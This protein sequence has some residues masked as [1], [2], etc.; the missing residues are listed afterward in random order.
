MPDQHDGQ[1]FDGAVLRQRGRRQRDA[2]PFLDVEQ[3][4][5]RL[6]E[7]AAQ[8]EKV[9]AHDEQVHIPQAWRGDTP[10]VGQF[11]HGAYWNEFAEQIEAPPQIIDVTSAHRPVKDGAAMIENSGA[12]CRHALRQIFPAGGH[13]LLVHPPTAA[14]FKF[15]AQ[16][17]PD[18]GENQQSCL[19]H[20][21]PDA[22]SLNHANERSRLDAPRQQTVSVLT[23]KT[24]QAGRP[25]ICA[26]VLV[27]SRCHE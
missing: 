24:R 21:R 13:D 18:L 10:G 14:H 26:F 8:L 4:F 5:H 27:T 12:K 19:H 15:Q 9:V 11:R 6:Q 16:R 2:Q 1:F 7:R 22:H 23:Q 3:H 25:R 17:L 20:L